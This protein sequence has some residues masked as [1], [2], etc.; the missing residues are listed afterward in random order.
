[1][2]LNFSNEE[3]HDIEDIVKK[4]T[5]TKEEYFLNLHK[6]NNLTKEVLQD[7]SHLRLFIEDYYHMLDNLYAYNFAL[8]E[9]IEQNKDTKVIDAIL[10]FLDTTIK[11]PLIL[12]Q[13][14]AIYKK[15]NEEKRSFPF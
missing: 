12:A 5:I 10:S 6:R 8:K 9:M 11:D 13:I 3:T 7:S 4:L 2:N 15:Q 14:Y 1:M